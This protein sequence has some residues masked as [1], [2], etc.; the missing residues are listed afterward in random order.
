M[1]YRE[2]ACTAVVE[3]LEDIG[4]E[5]FIHVPDSFG[6]PVISHFENKPGVRSFPVAREEEG[7]GIASGLAMTSRKVVL[8]YQDTGLGNSI[9][10][11]TTYAMAYHAPMLLLAIRRGGFGEFNS[12]NFHFSETAPDMVEA[13]KI[14]AFTLDY[15]VPL[16]KWADSIRGAYDYAHMT[17]RPIVVFLDLKD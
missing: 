13:M 17:R 9:G 12:A 7:I 6:A 11:L 15:Q 8:F 1:G 5:F 4:I 10:A 14:K 3:G 16:E 2:D